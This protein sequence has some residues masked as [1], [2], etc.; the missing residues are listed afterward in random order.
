MHEG[1]EKEHLA[2]N[3]MDMVSSLVGAVQALQSQVQELRA[4]GAGLRQQQR[5]ST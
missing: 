3:Y 1:T 4:E 2:V 5:A